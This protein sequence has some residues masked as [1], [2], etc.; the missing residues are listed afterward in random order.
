MPYCCGMPNDWLPLDVNAGRNWRSRAVTCMVPGPSATG[1]SNSRELP[2]SS[3][4][5]CDREG[6]AIAKE[7]CLRP[8]WNVIKNTLWHQ[9]LRQTGK[10]IGRKCLVDKLA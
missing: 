9:R 3:T 1:N 2:K 7:T 5:T 6:K 10:E 4:V 8:G